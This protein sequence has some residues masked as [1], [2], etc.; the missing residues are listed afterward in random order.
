MK[1]ISML[2]EKVLKMILRELQQNMMIEPTTSKQSS[3]LSSWY[4][5]SNEIAKFKKSLSGIEFVKNWAVKMTKV[6][7]CKQNCVLKIY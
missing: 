6:N 5:I 2:Q 4:N 3:F 1:Q 7:K